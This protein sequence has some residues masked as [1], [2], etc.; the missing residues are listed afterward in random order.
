LS[1]SSR[2]ALGF[3]PLA[4]ATRRRRRRI[5]PYLYL[6][7]S[8]VFLGT[9][10]YYPVLSSLEMSLHQ[11]SPVTHRFTFVGAANY[12]GLAHDPVFGQVLKNS[13]EF[14]IGTVP[15]TVGLA[16]ALAVGLS[17]TH[18]LT[19][20]FRTAF[21]YPTLLPLVGAA[22][23]WLFVYAPGY[24]LIDTYLRGLTPTGVGW[25]SSP[26]YALPAV[27][28]MTVWKNAG[29]YM[30]FYLA[31]L[32]TISAE[33]YEAARLEGASSWQQFRRITFPL[34]GPTTL[35]VL[36]IASINAF[37]SVDQIFVMTGGGPDNTTNL[38]LFYTYQAA[39][40]FFDF[41]KA[42]ALTVF[43][44]AVLM[45]IA[46]ISFGVLERRIHYEA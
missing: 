30:L 4:Q 44:L 7:P 27:I 32:Q 28:V 16:L 17:R 14:L 24:G 20:A 39:F 43:L 3:H 38:L 29:Y 37:Q 6:V 2:E 12:A 5:Q 45:L 22:A 46:A 13:A 42:A 35:F 15:V 41:G 1:T 34:L 36:V 31:G 21:F 11:L 10:T 26:V 25:L 8:L 9:F 40:M 18:A 33:L 19:T 23:I